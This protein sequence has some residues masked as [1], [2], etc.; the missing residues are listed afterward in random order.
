[1]PT[2]PHSFRVFC[3]GALGCPCQPGKSGVLG[4]PA[5]LGTAPSQRPRAGMLHRACQFCHF[6]SGVRL[7]GDSGNPQ[8]VT[9]SQSK[10]TPARKVSI[11][12]PC[13][14]GMVRSPGPTPAPWP[15][16]L[17]AQPPSSR[18]TT[19]RLLLNPHWPS[20]RLLERCLID[21][22]TPDTSHARAF[23]ETEPEVAA[24]LADLHQGYRNL[25]DIDSA[26]PR[27]HPRAGRGNRDI[28]QR[29]GT[30]GS[31]W[32]CNLPS[33]KRLCPQTA[34]VMGAACPC[35]ALP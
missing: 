1:M 14:S 18:H 8:P 35:R 16:I 11:L 23:F 20:V 12:S 28:R 13:T 3:W 10:G 31:G 19:L 30:G 7:R 33:A 26:R 22:S 34:V 29:E 27:P 6:L 21:A 9:K 32:Q 2:E 15:L 5:G 17:A 25:A 4:R 24:P